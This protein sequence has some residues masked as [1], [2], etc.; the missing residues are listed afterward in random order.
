MR[1]IRYGACATA[2]IAVGG[3]VAA[4]G[5]GDDSG[6]GAAS[7]GDSGSKAANIAFAQMASSN[8]SWKAQTSGVKSQASQDG[9]SLLVGDAG[10]DVVKQNSLVQTYITR[11][12]DA[13]IIN[14]ADPVGV[15]P[16]VKALKAA[17]IPMVV[18]NNSLDDSLKQDAYCYVAEDQEATGALVGKRMAEVLAK[19]DGGDKTLKAVILGGVP[20][21]AITP[22]RSDGFKKGYASVD[23]APKLNLMPTIY[24]KWS[25]EEALAPVREIATANPDLSVIFVASDSMLPAV[26]SAL[27]T[28]GMWNKVTIGSY[29]GEMVWVKEMMD[30]PKGPIVGIGANVP[31]QQ[32]ATAMQM[33]EQAAAGK[34]ASEAC[35]GGTKFI[36]T[37]LYTP[38]NAKQYYKPGKAF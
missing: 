36:K 32:G 14:P 2:L 37:P 6:G 19:R 30:D 1:G 31:D 16:S 13:L 10:G 38:E 23:G 29:D 18:V 11:Q 12:V 33:A 27:K 25:A 8:D 24:G 7:G 26:Q 35:P 4:C 20:G 34:P 15:G 28:L 17:K 22:V 5:S 9:V 21:D 3:L